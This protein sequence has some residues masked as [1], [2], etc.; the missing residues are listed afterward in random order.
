ML[1]ILALFSRF[2]IL[3]LVALSLRSVSFGSCSWK[4]PCRNEWLGTH[5]RVATTTFTTWRVQSLSNR[6]VRSDV[7]N[8]RALSHS[9]QKRSRRDRKPG[10][11]ARAHGTHAM[12]I[13]TLYNFSH[14]V[15]V[16]RVTYISICRLTLCDLSRVA[17]GKTS[18][19]SDKTLRLMSRSPSIAKGCFFLL[20]YHCQTCRRDP[21]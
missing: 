8:N 14:T 10:M 6:W 21:P 18:F 15:R 12:G 1:E 17:R 11:V 5:S 19:L 2:C 4:I 7:N 3:W 9:H 20:G 16:R 13:L